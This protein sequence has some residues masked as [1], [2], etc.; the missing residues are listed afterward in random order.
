MKSRRRSHPY[1]HGHRAGIHTHA[2]THTRPH[3][4]MPARTPTPHCTHFKPEHTPAHTLTRS[5][6]LA[7]VMAKA[8]VARP[9]AILRC[10]GT[11]PLWSLPTNNCLTCTSSNQQHHHHHPTRACIQC[12]QN[13]HSTPAGNQKAGI[14]PVIETCRRARKHPTASHVPQADT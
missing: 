1:L 9:E 6:G 11:S 7:T 13:Q 4:G 2:C 10:S 14:A 3:L 5:V 8:P 12:M